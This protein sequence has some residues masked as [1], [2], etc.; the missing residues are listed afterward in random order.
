MLQT[1]IWLLVKYWNDSKL[2][3]KNTKIVSA[4]IELTKIRLDTFSSVVENRHASKIM[5]YSTICNLF[6][7]KFN[8][9]SKLG[10]ADPDNHTG[11]DLFD[12]KSQLLSNLYN[13]VVLFGHTYVFPVVSFD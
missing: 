12:I 6:G 7:T 11:F 9:F 5:T 8:S 10:A 4:V 13:R 1:G 3:E 2:A